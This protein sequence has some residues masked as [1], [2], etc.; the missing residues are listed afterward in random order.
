MISY[1]L[2][3]DKNYS[4]LFEAIKSLS[5]QHTH[6]LKSTWIIKS[7]SNAYDIAAKLCEHIDTDDKLIVNIL[8]N[9]SSWTQSFGQEFTDWIQAD[10]GN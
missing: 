10:L 7:N 5:T 1:D 4:D 3:K 2:I 6:P 9:D 8:T